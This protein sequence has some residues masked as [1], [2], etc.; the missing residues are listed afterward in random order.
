VTLLADAVAESPLRVYQTVDGELEE[1][2]DHR[3]RTLLANPNPLMSEAEFMS[4]LVMA[5]GMW[6]YTFVEK[7]RSNAGLPVELWPLRPDWVVRERTGQDTT[8]IVYR[9]PGQDPRPIDED[10]LILVPYRHDERFSRPGVS[11]LQIVA[12]EIGIDVSLTDLL[13]VFI[14]SG[15]IPPWAI[16]FTGDIKLD[17][18]AKDTFRLMWQQRYGGSRAYGQIGILDPG[19]DLVKVGDSIGDMAWPDLRGLT[20]AKIAQ[21]FRV[22]LD[23]VQGRETL[24]SGSLTTTEMTGAMAFLQNHGAQPLRMR[25]DG[26]FSRSL[27]ADYGLDATYSLEFDTSGILAL[28]EDEDARHTR[29]RANFDAGLVTMNEARQ[30]LGL[31]DLGSDGEVIKTAF[32]T[33]LQPITGLSTPEPPERASASI[34]A[35]SGGIPAI[36]AGA[37]SEDRRYRDIKALSPVELEKRASVLTTTRRQMNALTEI[38][39]RQLR[40]FFKAQG[41]RIVNSLPKSANG[42]AIKAA[43]NWD[44]EDDLLAEVMNKYY[45]AI[46]DRA[47]TNVAATLDIS[48]DWTLANPNVARIMELLGH[49]IRDISETTR[50]EVVR[51]ITDGQSEGLTLAQIADNLT[52]LFEE[53]YSGRAATIARTETMIGWG[54]ASV[55]GYQESGVVDSVE[56]QDNPDHTDPY[57]GADDGLTCAERHELVVPL[58]QAM[59]HIG[60]DHPNGSAVAIPILS[61]PLGE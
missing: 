52:G 50:L 43:V 19:M 13:K 29:W 14:D 2:P 46:G 36:T 9:V 11:P 8:R 23:L 26:A 5:A 16:K 1:R 7:V 58:D 21:A 42:P 34:T 32:T 35:R 3:L 48:L 10:D 45:N 25:I 61:T 54:E 18:A 49:R 28:Q 59:F 39:T 44:D 31:P 57:D 12:R 24:S 40:R 53:T 47:F 4:L 6:G 37:K 60:S 17:Q 27:L 22:P 55:L 33:I 30:M 15:G 41:Q 56:I 51:V 38:G 20:E